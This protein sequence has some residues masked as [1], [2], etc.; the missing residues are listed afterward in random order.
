MDHHGVLFRWQLRRSAQTGLDRGRVYLHYPAGIT[1]RFRVLTY[2]QKAASRY[3][4]YVPF[5]NILVARA[6][7]TAAANVLLGANGQVKL[8]D[9]GVSGQLTATMTKKNTFVGTPFWMAPEVIKQSGYDHKADIWSL[10]ITALELANGEPPYSD[11][12]PMKVL[13][14]IPK[15]SPP[16]LQG[17]FSKP[18]KDFVELCLKRLPAER[19]SAKDLLK[20]PFIRKAKKTTYLTELLERYERWQAIH[21]DKESEDSDDSNEGRN[22]PDQNEDLWDFGTVRPMGGRGR[23][24]KDMNASAANAR[25]QPVAELK[26]ENR[27]P[28]K[29]MYQVKIEPPKDSPENTV[30]IHSPDRQSRGW[31]PQRKPLPPIQTPM[32]PSK[33]PLPPSPMRQAPPKPSHVKTPS[34]S[35]QPISSTHDS[36]SSQD[37]DR[38]LQ[39][40]LISDM[41][42]HNLGYDGKP[43]Q[44][45]S[46]NGVFDLPA[47]K[48]EQETSRKGYVI[49][50]IPPFRSISTTSSTQPLQSLSTPPVP[51][52]E[53]PRQQVAKQQ[54][55]LPSIPLNQGAAGHELANV[56]QGGSSP[57]HAGA[58]MSSEA[59]SQGISA[60]SPLTG[61][62]TGVSDGDIT[63]LNSVLI[64]A[65]QACLQRRGFSLNES[66]QKHAKAA[67][68]RRLSQGQAQAIDQADRRRQHLHEKMTKHVTKLAGVMSEIDR[69]DKE[70]VASGEV[71]MGGGIS[72][73]LEGFL[74]EILVRVE[75]ED[76]A[77]PG[78]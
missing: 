35:N 19:P 12:H 28:G 53:P 66:I 33:V 74:E 46:K 38:G 27:S 47:Q 21:G 65:I 63:P 73:F 32:S 18:F 54:Q 30:R 13:F 16:R 8:A 25:A 60:S 64:P 72:S 6:E 2:R 49:P 40:S 61:G 75:P 36:P 44:P 58:G 5:E 1:V 14:L 71:G 23:G 77:A 67:Q 50:E 52:H 59:S 3:Q 22:E 11:I 10:G 17:N 70:V 43:F 48:T 62:P 26:A 51:S 56:K 42:L 20:H 45:V 37:Y 4:R 68:S 24:L 55:P 41:Q 39:E 9:F 78:R 15:N 69:I 34:H 31:S 7:R 29:D 76:E 57:E